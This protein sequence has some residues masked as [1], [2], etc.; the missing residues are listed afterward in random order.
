M[1]TPAGQRPHWR[2]GT[3][4]GYHAF[5]I[6]ALTGE[7]VRRPPQRCRLRLHPAPLLLRRRRRRP[8][9]PRPGRRRG[10]RGGAAG[11]RTIF[12]GYLTEGVSLSWKT[13]TH[14]P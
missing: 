12:F 14:R 6:G 10:P 2:P 11:R 13:V 5:V 9:E 4:Y 7:V 3:A 8:G 1:T